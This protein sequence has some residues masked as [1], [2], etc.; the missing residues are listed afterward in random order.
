MHAAIHEEQEITEN[1]HEVV[2]QVDDAVG[3]PAVRPAEVARKL[4]R[5]HGRLSQLNRLRLRVD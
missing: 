3:L 2:V 4:A 1:T 5:R